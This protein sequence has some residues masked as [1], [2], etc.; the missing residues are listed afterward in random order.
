[1]IY[2]VVPRELEAE[3]FDK[4]TAYYAADDNVTVIVDRRRGGA[5]E[6]DAALALH[7]R[8]G[9]RPGGERRRRAGAGGLR[10]PPI[11]GTV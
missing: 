7:A 10:L 5:R 9:P 6:L 8:T 1:V 4:L 2:C 3:L 11:D